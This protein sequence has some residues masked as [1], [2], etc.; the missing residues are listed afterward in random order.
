MEEVLDLVAPELGLIFYILFIR[1]VFNQKN[2]LIGDIRFFYSEFEE[3]FFWRIGPVKTD[4]FFQFTLQNF[5]LG[6]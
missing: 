5:C 6:G 3:L 2:R 4:E 1:E